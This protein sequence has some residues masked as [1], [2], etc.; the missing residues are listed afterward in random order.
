MNVRLQDSAPFF[1]AVLGLAIGTLPTVLLPIGTGPFVF[2]LTGIK[3]IAAIIGFSITAVGIRCYR[4]GNTRVAVLTGLTV[5]GL[6]ALGAAARHHNETN[7]SL[8]PIWMWWLAV[9][10]I[11]G[12]AHQSAARIAD[13]NE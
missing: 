2:L 10:L 12:V 6:L 8:I 5:S 13:G 1:V 3:I 4:T 9:P 7:M 11:V